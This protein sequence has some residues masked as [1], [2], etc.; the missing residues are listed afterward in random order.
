M[1]G[2]RSAVPNPGDQVTISG[3]FQAAQLFPD[4]VKKAAFVYAQYP[5]TQE[6]R[7]K[8]AAGICRRSDTR[9]K[10]F[11][12]HLGISSRE[13]PPHI[14]PGNDPDAPVVDLA[15]IEEARDV[16]EPALSRAL[17][18][19]LRFLIGFF[20][21]LENTEQRWPPLGVAVF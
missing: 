10:C 18:G 1:R 11:P 12:C 15:T 21:A 14:T 16:A 17:E 7:D 8:Y 5:A 9:K 3:A 20:R 2:V 13:R 4:A 19:L 6:P